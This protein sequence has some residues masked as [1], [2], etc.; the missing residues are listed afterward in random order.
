M[1]HSRGDHWILTSNIG[2]ADGVVNVYDSVYRTVDKATSAVITSLFRSSAIKIVKS[3]K[4]KGGTDCGVFTIATATATA[5][6]HGIM[7]PSSFDQT[8]MRQHPS[9]LFQRTFDDCISMLLIIIRMNVIHDTVV[10][11]LL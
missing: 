1:I 4:L 6:A 9:K 7:T 3:P 2:G 5:L 8:A 11:M 10:I